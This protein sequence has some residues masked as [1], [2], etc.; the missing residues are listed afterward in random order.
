MHKPT[1]K[2]VDSGTAK[3]ASKSRLWI[4]LLV[5]SL[6]LLFIGAAITLL[7]RG[8]EQ[9]LSL[10]GKGHN[11]IVLVHDHNT[12]SSLETMNAMNALRDEYEGRVKFLVADIFTPEGKRFADAHGIESTGL[13]FFAPN[14]EKLGI[15]YGQQDVEL[16]RKNLSKE[17]H[18]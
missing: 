2:Q 9:D 3:T 6:I 18:F 5:I 10:I 4:T 15:A 8:Y 12:V 13:V 7:P 11:V 14:G 1:G 17:F 16:L